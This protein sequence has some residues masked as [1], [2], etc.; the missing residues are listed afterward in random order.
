MLRT[1]NITRSEGVASSYQILLLD[2]EVLVHCISCATMVSM[3]DSR[4]WANFIL[5]KARPG[6]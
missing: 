5:L 3:P 4:A 1:S 2:V 6:S